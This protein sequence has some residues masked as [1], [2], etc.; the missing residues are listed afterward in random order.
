MNGPG[1]LWYRLDQMGAQLRDGLAAEL[2]NELTE[3]DRFGQLLEEFG[4][5]NDLPQKLVFQLTLAFD[6]L[7]TN[8]IS[9]GFPNGGQHTIKASVTLDEER[10]VA[11]IIDAGIAFNPLDRDTP[12]TTLSIE[13][14]RI[15]GL[16]VHFVR[17]FMDEVEYR[18]DGKHNRITM[19]KSLKPSKTGDA[20]ASGKTK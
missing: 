16:G 20:G 12:D 14:R 11:E 2:T 3:V 9:Y 8:T 1:F 17:T 15:G 7:L 13:E 6:E 18:R 10:L 19:A 4:E 5:R